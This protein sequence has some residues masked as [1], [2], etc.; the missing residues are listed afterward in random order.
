MSSH[1]EFLSDSDVWNHSLCYTAQ[2]RANRAIQAL[3]CNPCTECIQTHHQRNESESLQ[4]THQQASTGAKAI[5]APRL[6]YA[7]LLASIQGY[8]GLQFHAEMMCQLSRFPPCLISQS[9]Q[10]RL[11]GLSHCDFNQT[12]CT[13]LL[14]VASHGIHMDTVC[15]PHRSLQ[16]QPHSRKKKTTTRW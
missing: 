13:T 10:L 4:T 14:T 2:A 1:L 15:L 11:G 12:S 8:L 3:S 5:F 9:E 7:C 6:S 16:I